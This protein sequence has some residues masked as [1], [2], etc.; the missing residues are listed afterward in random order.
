[1]EGWQLVC[2][3]DEAQAGGVDEQ[4]LVAVYHVV[5]NYYVSN[6]SDV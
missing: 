4:R 1:M 2:C 3:G 6:A 5:T